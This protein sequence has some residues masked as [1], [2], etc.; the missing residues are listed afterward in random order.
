MATIGTIKPY[1]DPLEDWAYYVERFHKYF[2][3]NIKL[4]ES[5]SNTRFDG[6]K[7]LCIINTSKSSTISL[8]VHFLLLKIPKI[9][10]TRRNGTGPLKILQQIC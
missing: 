10:H 8:F 4:N 7:L 6:T 3:V 1:V 5:A 2:T 9:N